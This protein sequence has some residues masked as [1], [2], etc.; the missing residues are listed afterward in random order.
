M[1]ELSHPLRACMQGPYV[2]HT[3]CTLILLH[4]EWS[5]LQGDAGFW[6]DSLCLAERVS[7]L[8]VAGIP[9]YDLL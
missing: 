6:L 9:Y 7:S 1:G 4:L 3:R 8:H 2:H 5:T